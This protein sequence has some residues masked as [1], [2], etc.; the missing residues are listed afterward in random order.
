MTQNIKQLHQHAQ[1]ALNNKKYQQAHGYLLAILQQDKH[2]ADGYFLLGIIASDHKNHTKAIQLFEQAL[3]L[4]ENNTEYLAQLA[5]SFALEGQP[6]KA[7]K[8]ADLACNNSNNSALTLDTL[9]VTYSKIGLHGKAVV[10]FKQAVT[11]QQGNP[12]YYFNLGVSQTFTGDFKGAQASHEK[13]IA[14]EPF[15]CKSYTALSSYDGVNSK[16]Y[17]KET[18][19]QLLEKVTNPDD[20]LHI[21]HAL[22]REYEHEKNYELAYQTLSL[23]K[24]CKLN[25]LTYDFAEDKAMFTG[26]IDAFSH[27]DEG[28]NKTDTQTY[29]NGHESDEPIFIVGMPRTGTTLVERILSQHTHVTTAGELDYF[30]SLFKKMSQTPTQRI[31]DK[32]TIN[33]AKNIDFKKLG[34]TYIEYTRILTGGTAKF[35][36]KM[37]LNVLYVGFILKALPKAKIICLDR[38]PLDTIMSNFRQ[39]F[40]ANSYNY[41][42]AYS[43]KTVAQYYVEFKQLVDLWLEKY[44]DNF[45]QINYQTLVNESEIEAKKLIGFCDL[46]WQEQCLEISKNSAPVATASAVQVRKPINNKSIDNWK[47]YDIHLSEVKEIL[48]NANLL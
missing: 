13:V 44:P 15:Y 32:E 36:D 12:F 2:F 21:G 4:T 43:L 14:L 34:Q 9:G 40:S 22:A 11:I 31:L 10:L 5:K 27:K 25:S 19:R 30:G 37:P 46:D 20:K 29:K 41:N 3:K 7:K 45:Y 39:L 33:G 35:I 47:K 23:A 8:Y 26:L 48:D 17:N 28:V 6:I 38:N 18:L 24:N 42:Y 16:N 1:K